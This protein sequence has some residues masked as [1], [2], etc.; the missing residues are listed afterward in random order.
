MRLALLLM[1]A[2]AH[3]A[4]INI[5]TVSI[6]GGT[7]SG[8]ATSACNTAGACDG[9]VLE[10]TT[11]SSMSTGGTYALGFTQ[12]NNNIA[13]A[14]K[15]ALTVTSTGYTD[16][17]GTPGTV[18]RT[19]Y[20]TA[21][22]RQPSPNQTSADENG[23][24]TFRLALSDAIYAGET[25]TAVIGAGLYAQGADSTAAFSG[26]V[27]N[28]STLA[29]SK[30]RTIANWSGVP[31]QRVGSSFTVRAV[32]F[33]RH[34]R[35]GL[36]V[37]CVVFTA[38]DQHAHT[39]TVAVPRPT[40]DQ[41]GPVLYGD[42]AAVTEYIG[43][44][45][46]STL[47]QGDLLTVHFKAYPWVGDSTA[48]MDTSD[49]V[50]AQP[51]PLYAPHY[52]V[53]DRTGAYGTAAAY[54]DPAT[55]NDT[56]NCAVARTAFNSSSPPP[57]CATIRGAAVKMAAFNNTN[58]S[59]NTAEGDMYLA[60]GTYAW[61]GS[62]AAGSNVTGNTWLTIQPFPGVASSSV[63]IGSQSGSQSFGTR[64]TTGST[65][66]GTPIRLKDLYVTLPTNP[67]SLITTVTY[68]WLDNVRTDSQCNATYYQN[69]VMWMTNSTVIALLQGIAPYSNANASFALIRGVTVDGTHK[70]H[71]YTALANSNNSVREFVWYGSITSGGGP[72]TNAPIL[73]FNK[74]YKLDIASPVSLEFYHNTAV[75]SGVLGAAF[76]QN[77]FENVVGGGLTK[78]AGLTSD[79]AALTPVNNIMMWHNTLTGG[80]INRCYNDSG[81]T[82]YFRTLWSEIG[83]IHDQEAFKTDTWTTANGARVGNWACNYGVGRRGMVNVEVAGWAATGTFQLEFGGISAY[84]PT[85]TA[86]THPPQSGTNS[87][88]FVKYVNRAS[89]ETVTA[90]GGGDYRLR[91]D[92][93]AARIIPAGQA[94][95]PYD[96]DG[97][98]RR[99]DGHGSAGPYEQGI[100]LTPVF[101]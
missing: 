52:Y 54:V 70:G 30:A 99:N 20:A 18:T 37:A 6:V 47:D 33:Q 35:N 60:A 2:T 95:L 87:G 14:A 12:S 58:Y 45:D 57:P 23:T 79:A 97:K 49:G 53:N 17:S 59:R 86:G 98:I 22:L 66:C 72:Q 1:A 19:V 89:Y 88:S 5:S 8:V 39:V 32:A 3:A 65:N 34:A 42:K 44:I 81:T 96:L 7:A 73:A 21:R 77:I 74:M 94:V 40:V 43:T 31:W 100:L 83:G 48:A 51:T 67:T 101:F 93:P 84:N 69:T 50:N 55:G 24:I 90:A 9:W 4:V 11:A 56:N 10:V 36:P 61:M 91:S 13:S 76:V 75:P 46:T 29:Y 63:V 64:C 92:S 26:A 80:R 78:L 41:Q 25:V 85:L 16:C 27:T 28:N 62:A 71:V 38:T 15:V 82:P 68:L